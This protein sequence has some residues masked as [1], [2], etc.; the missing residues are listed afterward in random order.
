[1][2]HE[3]SYSNNEHCETCNKNRDGTVHPAGGYIFICAYCANPPQPVKAFRKAKWFVAFYSR[4]AKY[5]AT[6]TKAE[7]AKRRAHFAAAKAR[8]NARRA[9]EGRPLIGA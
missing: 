8:I 7:R 6:T 1:M 9:A 5:Y 2:K 4:K 3:E